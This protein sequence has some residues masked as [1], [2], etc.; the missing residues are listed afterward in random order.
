MTMAK[1]PD[2][3]PEAVVEAVKAVSKTAAENAATVDAVNTNAFLI[4]LFGFQFN[5]TTIMIVTMMF[6]ALYIFW[7][8]QSS[9]KLDFADMLT[10]DGQKVSSTKVMQLIGGVAATWVIIK[11]CLA[12]TLSE[13][14]FGIYLAFMAGIEGYSKFISAKYNYNETS[15]RDARRRGG[16]DRGRDR[17]PADPEFDPPMEVPEGDGPIEKTVTA[18]TTPAGTVIRQTKVKK[19]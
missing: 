16:G 15:M 1:T 4:D 14:V 6:G 19:G 9:K 7:K 2:V 18:A 10:K 17:D 11:L 13:G 3:P 8:L 12:G 5:L